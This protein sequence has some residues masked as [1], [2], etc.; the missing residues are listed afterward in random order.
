MA[1]SQ[2]S[3][4]LVTGAGGLLGSRVVRLLPNAIPGARVLAVRR[5][6]TGILA[7]QPNVE[8][9]HGDLRDEQLWASLPRE[10][11]QVVHLAAMIPWKLEDR[12]KPSVVTENIL[13]LANLIAQSRHW[14]NLQQVIYSSSVSVYTPSNK[15]LNEESPA[16]PTGLYGAAKLAGENLLS[17]LAA[18]GVHTVSLRLSSLYGQGQYAGTVLPLMVT[19]ARQQQDL[20][21]FGDGSRCQDFLDCDDAARAILLAFQKQAKGTYNVGCGVAV[22]MKELAET[23]NRV[24]ADG[25]AKIVMQPEKSENDPGLKL[26]IGKARR[27]LEFQSLM[28]LETGLRK[29]KV[30]MERASNESSQSHAN[31]TV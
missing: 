31:T 13:P 12:H 6:E 24:F 4:I 19:R 25:R 14:P 21:L 16:Q 2:Q 20:L 15:V 22:S 10:I 3:V 28:T 1:Q 27:E 23:I 18:R 8:T 17:C 11:T 7:D 5:K 26:N 9:I 30:E 29:L